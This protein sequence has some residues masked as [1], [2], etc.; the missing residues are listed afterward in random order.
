MSALGYL[1]SKSSR[2]AGNFALNAEF[3]N[4]SAKDR[5]RLLALS[6]LTFGLLPLLQAH[7][8]FG[9]GIITVVVA[10]MEVSAGLH[11]GCCRRQ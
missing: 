2:P 11:V 10:L 4:V 1:C 7:S 5:T 6:G 9:V 3:L 8:F